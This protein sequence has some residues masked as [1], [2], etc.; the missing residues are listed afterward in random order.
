LIG[1]VSVSV[2][3]YFSL[4]AQVSDVAFMPPRYRAVVYTSELLRRLSAHV[5]AL[6]YIADSLYVSAIRQQ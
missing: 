5:P 2:D 4:N 1:P 3:G 6:S